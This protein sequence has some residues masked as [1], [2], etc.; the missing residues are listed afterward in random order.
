MTSEAPTAYLDANVLLAYIRG[1]ETRVDAVESVLTAAGEGKLSVHTSTL[2]I[3]E[4]AY[5][6]DEKEQQQL[7]GQ[8]ERTI[9]ELWQAGSPVLLI[10]PSVVVMRIARQ[11][12]R[13]A[14]AGGRS[15]KPADSVH[16]A[17][18]L[19]HPETTHVFTY[20]KES[21]RQYWAEL[22]GLEV[23]EPYVAEPRLPGFS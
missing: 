16:L 9:D 1:E 15:L 11:L 21:R 18:A 19:F 3:V 6:A 22:T 8:V 7:D 5:G 23:A 12:V 13:R 2:S 10:E 4:V 14:I 20:E 17:T